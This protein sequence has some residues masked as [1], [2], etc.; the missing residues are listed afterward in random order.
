MDSTDNDT[1]LGMGIEEGK[2]MSGVLHS[3]VELMQKNGHD[4]STKD[5][6]N[7]EF[8]FRKVFLRMSLKLHPDKGGNEADF[9]A[10][11]EVNGFVKD[12]VQNY[13]KFSEDVNLVNW[14]CSDPEYMEQQLKEHFA[15]EQTGKEQTGAKKQKIKRKHTKSKTSSTRKKSKVESESVKKPSESVSGTVVNNAQSQDNKNTQSHHI[16]TPL[17]EHTA[18]THQKTVFNKMQEYLK[19]K[20]VDIQFTSL[21]TLKNLERVRSPS[22]L[23]FY[24]S[25]QK[26]CGT[27]DDALWYI[28][29]HAETKLG[30]NRKA[31]Y[32]LKNMMGDTGQNKKRRLFW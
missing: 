29:L 2:A 14:Y 15:K 21:I 11:N 17:V 27:I 4:V 5:I 31:H 23:E 12:Y 28:I 32:W 13:D 18:N 6:C 9:A 22:N 26:E 24:G 20:E 25:L 30:C 3:V 10:L 8:N 1:V 16:Y 7:P 19:T